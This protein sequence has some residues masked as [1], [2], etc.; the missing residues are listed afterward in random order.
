MIHVIATVVLE[1]GKE[2]E[3]LKEL[4]KIVPS[5]QAED[6]CIEYFPTHDIPTGIPVQKT[7]VENSITILERWTNVDALKIHLTAPHMLS[8]REAVK[9]Y[10]KQVQIRVL[11][12]L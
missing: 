7:I 8:Y 2:S 3:Y 5:V 1:E 4:W 9:D 6:G 11:G 12:P 10:V